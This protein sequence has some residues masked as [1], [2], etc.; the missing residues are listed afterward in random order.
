VCILTIICVHYQFDSPVVCVVGV[1]EE[2]VL[3]NEMEVYIDKC[4]R[5]NM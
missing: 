4:V 2:A 5:G 1:V 3:Q